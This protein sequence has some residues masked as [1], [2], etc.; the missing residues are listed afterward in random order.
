[1]RLRLM[2][3]NAIAGLTKNEPDEGVF[4]TAVE[5]TQWANRDSKGKPMREA[6]NFVDTAKEMMDAAKGEKKG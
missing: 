6:Q 3:M 4:N 1:M 5:L 2:I